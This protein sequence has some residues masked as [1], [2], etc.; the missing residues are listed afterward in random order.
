MEEVA[1]LIKRLIQRIY[2]TDALLTGGDFTLASGSTSRYYFDGKLLTLD[3]E[4]NFLVGKLMFELLR[5]TGVAAVGGLTIGADPIAGAIAR[6]SYLTPHLIPGFIVREN[7]KTHGRML[8]IEGHLP[9]GSNVKVAIVDD[10]ITR[11]GSIRKAIDRVEAHGCEVAKILTVVDRH[12]GGSEKLKEEGYDFSTI[13]GLTRE[14]KPFVEYP[15]FPPKKAK[16][17]FAAVA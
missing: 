7:E 8:G 12:E 9:T 13:L 4:G 17:I 11:G 14:G 3:P 10:V 1:D 15:G 16:D 5:D 2:E 6:E